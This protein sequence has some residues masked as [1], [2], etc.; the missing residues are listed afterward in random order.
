MNN[1][2]FF[3]HYMAQPSHHRPS[4]YISGLYPARTGGEAYIT[5]VDIEGMSLIS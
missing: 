3:L 1:P 5:P 2:F 4:D